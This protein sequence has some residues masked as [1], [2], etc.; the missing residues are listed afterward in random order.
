MSAARGA[1]LVVIL[2]L[3]TGCRDATPGAPTGPGW[4]RFDLTT[5]APVTRR[6]PGRSAGATA[7][8]EVALSSIVE[9]PA[10]PVPGARIR[11]LQ[12]K[13]GGGEASWRVEVG[14]NAYLSFI[15]LRAGSVGCR[16][17]YH[18]RIAPEGAGPRD[19]F[20]IEPVAARREAPETV[21]FDLA[22]WEGTAIVLSLRVDARGAGCR[23]GAL[24]QAVWGSPAI[25][26]R[27]A[28]IAPAPPGAK[29]N[30]ILISFDAMR[31]D[32]IGPR[33]GGVTLTPAIDRFALSADVWTS[34][35]STF[36]VTNPSF[37]SIM[38]GLYG[39]HHGVLGLNSPLP[40]AYNTL[41]ESLRRAGY[42]TSAVVSAQ[43]LADDSSGLGQGFDDYVVPSVRFGAETAT[44][45][46]ID[47][48]SNGGAEP[49]FAWVHYFEPHTPHE[50]PLPWS[51]GLR[52]AEPYGLAPVGRWVEFRAPGA[53]GYRDE[54]LRAHEALC[55]AEIAYVDRQVDRLLGFLESRGLLER[56]IVAIVS[57]HGENLPGGPA[58][59]RHV[60][61]FDATTRVPLMIRRPGYGHARHDELVQTIDIFPTLLELA[62]VNAAPTDGRSLYSAS[63]QRDAVFAQHSQGGG[64]MVRDRRFLY[65]TVRGNPFIADGE[66]LFDVERDPA[67]R[68]NLAA[69]RPEI[70]AAYRDRLRDWLGS[71]P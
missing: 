6:M 18:A 20:S 23:A 64:A 48:L 3:A 37:A 41:A 13:P 46:A 54:S 8:V 14:A 70:A 10:T 27:S 7:P 5:N 52:A 39:I 40:G 47:Q 59:F 15:P 38:T 43:H 53:V 71:E 45:V 33:P 67:Q 58:P 32:A 24:E 60:G 9:D 34:A 61:L 1:V 56:T 16:Y 42:R 57:D 19:D 2:L 31:R 22:R 17:R 50:A 12:M 55:D 63:P 51:D 25:Y 30:I 68:T 65:S 36:N 28:P 21:T 11:G 4:T 35:Y 44:D 49:F 66:F 62:G 29:P 26:A 69:S